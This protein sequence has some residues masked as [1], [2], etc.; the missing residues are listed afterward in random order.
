MELPSWK[1]AVI[2]TLACLGPAL[3]QGTF[4]L[5]Y[6][7]QLAELHKLMKTEIG[8]RFRQNSVLNAGLIEQELLP[9]LAECTIAIRSANQ[10]LIERIASIRPNGTDGVSECWDTVDS[11][12]Y[13]HTLLPQW[14]LQ[15]CAYGGYSQWMRD[16]ARERFYP[17]AL[18]LHRIS[19]EVINT[20]VGVVSEDDP[21][22]DAA[23]VEGRLD[24]SLDHFNE[25]WIDGLQ[26][27]EEDLERHN[28]RQQAIEAYMRE[29]IDR[30]ISTS[31]EDVEYTVRYAEFFCV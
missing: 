3:V 7:N 2:C 17:R 6:Q 12:L 5:T 21:V 28:D 27:L 20:I 15:D 8:Q 13:V 25:M 14:D 26:D 29:C 30:T 4:L 9:V 16:D 19:S 18:E 22:T 31:Q 11:L 23:E 24:A 10:D 1:L